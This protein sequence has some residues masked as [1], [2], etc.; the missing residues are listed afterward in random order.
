MTTNFI[1]TKSYP[2]LLYTFLESHLMI[3]LCQVIYPCNILPMAAR[4]FVPERPE[5]V[6][7]VSW[8]DRLEINLLPLN[9][10]IYEFHRLST[11]F[12]KHKRSDAFQTCTFKK[13]YH[14]C[15]RPELIFKFMKIR[16]I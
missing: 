6:G 12:R 11:H 15:L 14:S 10:L 2:A 5:K 7:Q 4:L 1:K 13:R 16:K 3:R 8:K 9:S